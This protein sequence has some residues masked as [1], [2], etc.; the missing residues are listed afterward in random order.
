MLLYLHLD[1]H[2]IRIHTRASANSHP[3]Q[4]PPS[5]TH[6]RVKYNHSD[7][8]KTPHAL[9]ISKPMEDNT[10]WRRDYHCKACGYSLYSLRE[11][12]P[13]P[14]YGQS[15]SESVKWRRSHPPWATRDLKAAAGMTAL[16]I[17]I[18]I[19]FFLSGKSGTIAIPFLIAIGFLIVTINA[20]F[21][22]RRALKQG[23]NQR[24]RTHFILWFN[25]LL[26]VAM[27]VMWAWA[28]WILTHMTWPK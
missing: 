23:V 10:I 2:L 27:F 26:I 5:Q 13:C 25:V 28:Y 24:K 17:L 1:R 22:A 4:T 7:S 3:K 16:A 19:S 14:E 11:Q 9:W 8:P 18:F 21:F 6:T 15:I 12:D 20:I